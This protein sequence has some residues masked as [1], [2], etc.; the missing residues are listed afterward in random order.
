[1]TRAFS[2]YYTSNLSTAKDNAFLGIL[3]RDLLQVMYLIL[4]DPLTAK[5]DRPEQFVPS[6]RRFLEA[7]NKLPPRPIDGD[8]SDEVYGSDDAFVRIVESVLKV[9]E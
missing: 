4:L 1:L 7:S 9:F 5:E 8:D 6:L 3:T 2:E